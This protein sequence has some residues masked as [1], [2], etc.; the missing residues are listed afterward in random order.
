M[1][2]SLQ[3]VAVPTTVSILLILSV[4]LSS[5]LLVLNILFA[6]MPIPSGLFD[7]RGD[8]SSNV[9]HGASR[10]LSNPPCKWSHEY[11]RSMSASATVVESRPS[12]DVWLTNG[13]AVDRKGKISRAMTMLTPMP[14]LSVLPPEEGDD[15]SIPPLPLRNEDSSLSVTVHNTPNSEVSAELGR[16][17]NSTA[18]SLRTSG[19]DDSLAFASKIM[20]AQRHY[21]SLAQT[22]L[23]PG[24]LSENATPTDDLGAATGAEPIR[25]ARHS[26]HLRTR[27]ISFITGTKAP[28][29][30]NSIKISPPPSFPLPPTPPSVRA[31]RLASLAHKKSFSS[32]FSFG[33]VDDMNEIDALTAG[34]L[35]LLV[36]GLNVNGMKIKEG[37][38]TPPGTLSKSKGRKL[39]KRLNEF[40]AD[41]SSPEVHSTPARRRPRDPK[42]SKGSTHKRNHLSL[43]RYDFQA[44][45]R[46]S[47]DCFLPFSLGLGKD[48]VHSLATW[49]A[50]IRGAL[51][52]KVGLYTAVP[53]NVEL[54]RRNTV[55]GAETTPNTIPN[56]HAQEDGAPSIPKSG[57]GFG[58]SLSIRT[59]GLRPEVPHGVDTAR[60]SMV[61]T[62]VPP[63][64]AASTVTLFEDFEAGIISSPQAESTPHNTI[65][66]PLKQAAPPPLPEQNRRPSIVYIKS[67]NND[68]HTNLPVE[69]TPP[70]AASFSR[71]SSW[72]VRPLM[73]KSSVLQRKL[74]TLN[75]G[76]RPGSP[77]GGLRTLSLLQDRNPNLDAAG[78]ATGGTRPL[79]PRKKQKPTAAKPV[80]DENVRP[81]STSIGRSQ[82]LRPLMLARS[83][84]SK[85]R[86]IIRKDEVLPDVVVRPPSTSDHTG[87]A[88]S[89]R[90]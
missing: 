70:S 25:I 66:K 4:T 59:L 38:W 47:A 37:D 9:N 84:T 19:A 40:G 41:F 88:Y 18:S 52:H 60:S 69:L 58:R 22:V 71:W 79:A 27:S 6:P 21:S 61:S 55:F 12:G 39:A 85:M 30:P 45:T 20:I 15:E 63:P 3:N 24:P 8:L 11:K 78:P 77:N 57:T 35:P 10:G 89:F 83:D 33:R 46:T 74:S 36:P 53:S 90:D 2:T 73:P 13:D 54:G 43:P 80:Q 49:G 81:G 87:F 75:S 51:E 72:A 28:T 26:G 56:F 42:L 65:S 86:G 5:P 32:G 1:I 14:K 62:M 64:S 76:T 29:T 68:P 16:L 31:A 44:G 7:S 67:E 34:V 48:G 50:D 23:V 17:R 82:K